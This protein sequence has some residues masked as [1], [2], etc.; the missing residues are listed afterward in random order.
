MLIVKII[1]L[2]SFMEL[3]LNWWYCI[4]EYEVFLTF[5]GKN[6]SDLKA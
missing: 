3:S 4:Y 2:P 6:K 5:I 1:N